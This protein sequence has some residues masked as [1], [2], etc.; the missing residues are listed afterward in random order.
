M[1]RELKYF[2]NI[3]F[4]FPLNIFRIQDLLPLKIYSFQYFQNS[5]HFT[6]WYSTTSQHLLKRWL[7]NISKTNKNKLRKLNGKTNNPPSL[8]QNLHLML[9]SSKSNQDTKHKTFNC[10]KYF[11]CFFPVSTRR[12]LDIDSIFERYGRQMNVKTTLCAY[13]VQVD[14]CHVKRHETN[15]WI[16]V[17]E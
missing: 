13:L 5:K 3:Q 16:L 8:F 17:Q 1:S 7:W 15:E 9:I 10:M 12:C 14:N 11:L 6:S 4:P 2:Y